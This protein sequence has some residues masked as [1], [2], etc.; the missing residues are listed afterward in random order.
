M[1][2]LESKITNVTVFSDR[3][4]ISRQSKTEI[5][6]GE[7]VLVFDN[8]PE[9]LDKNSIQVNGV[10]NAI[11]KSI[12][13]KEE[14]FEEDVNEIILEL[15][16]KLHKLQKQKNTFISKKT[17]IQKEKTFVDNI[18]IKITSVNKNSEVELN[19]EKWIKMTDFYRERLNFLDEELQNVNSE[20]EKLDSEEKVIHAQLNQ[21]GNRVSNQR[22]IVEVIVTS[23]EKSEINLLLNYIVY[24]VSWTPQ[25]NVRVNSETKK[26]QLEYNAIITQ[27]T[28]E[29]WKDVFLKLSTAQVQ[30]GGTMP[31]LQKWSVDVFI[32]RPPAPQRIMASPKLKKRGRKISENFDEMAKTEDL[33]F[34]SEGII[35]KPK[36]EVQA[37]HSSVVFVP[38]GK[39][40]ILSDNLDYTASIS[41]Q[42]FD[43]EFIYTSA[44]KLTPYIYLKA[45]TVNES[46]YPLLAGEMNV[47]FDNNFV[48]ESYLELT[49]PQE[50]F[51]LSLGVDES[52]KISHKQLKKYK[53]HE[54]IISKRNVEVFEYEI[55]VKNTK[56][57]DEIVTIKD[58]IPVSLDD[59]IKVELLSPKYKEDTENIQLDKHG[60]LTQKIEIKS[61]EEQKLL[62]KFDVEYPKE[63]KIVGL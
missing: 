35:E 2:I 5:P 38:A 50:D 43:T 1:T 15:H 40:T 13:F 21:A 16:E 44:P 9:N 61:Q 26:L 8:L 48:A 42:D 22:N 25:Y 60:I 3:A 12:K 24:N 37:Q 14:Y 32:P 18:A 51:S 54:G 10:G 47:F 31:K 58:N 63:T 55:S 62:I 52:I 29:D 59:N 56:S 49:L 6:Q 23:E 45:K 19:P 41:L 36:A 7:H 53:K 11:I 17:N 34:E 57:T 33:F 39:Y 46:E 4:Q 27:N 30:V 28:D 20:I